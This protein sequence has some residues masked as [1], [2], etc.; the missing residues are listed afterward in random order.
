MGRLL[1]FFREWPVSAGNG[2][3]GLVFLVG[4]L[5]GLHL[6]GEDLGEHQ[7]EHQSNHQTGNDGL[8]GTIEMDYAMVLMIRI[9]AIACSK[10]DGTIS[11]VQWEHH[12]SLLLYTMRMVPYIP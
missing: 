2:R 9:I 8:A 4:Q 7:E 3:G 5:G 12:L 1:G 11:I 6:G 10:M